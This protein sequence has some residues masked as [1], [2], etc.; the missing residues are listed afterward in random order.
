[1][2]NYAE[3]YY[4]TPIN[5]VINI[6][7]IVTIHYFEF[8]SDYIFRGEKHDFWEFLYVDK[9]EVEVMADTKGYKLTQGDIIFHK[10]NEFHSEWANG[11]VAPN[12]M[13]MSFECKDPAMDY[14]SNKIMQI[15]AS[16]K[17]LIAEIVK[18]SQK[19]Y[20]NAL[21]GHNKLLKHENPLFGS[22]QLIKIHLEL[23]LIKLIR[24]GSFDHSSKR[25]NESTLAKMEKGLVDDIIEYMHE[26]IASDLTF[27]DICNHFSLGK[28]Y[29]K[30]LFKTNTNL[31][32]MTYFK[33]LKINE[34]KTLIREQ[35]Y[36][37]TQIAYM[38]GYKS[39]HTFSRS[40][41]EAT[42]MSPSEY[43][44]S[45]KAMANL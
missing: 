20:S 10:P 23:L 35:Q 22:E 12:L 21:G 2:N 5:L 44:T 42:D 29:L 6:D 3:E 31:G 18:E 38:L 26:N 45:V 7:K 14:F 32:A 8:A 27:E 24:K 36:N 43:A 9:G 4:K 34:A 16:E 25:L 39:V 15:E 41:K 33:N 17:N 30:T 13:I 19:A 37:F 40:F 28:T 1:M 11:K